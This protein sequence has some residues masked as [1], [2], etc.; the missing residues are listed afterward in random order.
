MGSP[1][2]GGVGSVVEGVEGGVESPTAPGVGFV[3][4]LGGHVADELLQPVGGGGQE[5]AVAVGSDAEDEPFA[6]GVEQ[7]QLSQGGG[8]RRWG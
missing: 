6:V 2:S 1:A 4:G 7:L 5:R 3:V 8:P